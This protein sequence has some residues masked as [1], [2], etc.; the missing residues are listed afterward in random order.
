MTDLYFKKSKSRGKEYLQVWSRSKGFVV[1]LGSAE[2][3][4]CDSV[5]L[6]ELSKQTETFDKF[7]TEFNKGDVD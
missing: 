5:R 4:Y 1:S 6:K 3:C 2:K 7:R